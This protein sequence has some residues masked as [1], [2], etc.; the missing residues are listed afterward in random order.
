MNWCW[1]SFV[2]RQH[3][4]IV[5]LSGFV[6]SIL[7]TFLQAL[8]AAGRF[9]QALVEFHRALR[10]RTV[11][12][13]YFHWQLWG[14]YWNITLLY[15]RKD[16]SSIF[17][18]LKFRLRSSSHYEEWIN[19]WKF[20]CV[21]YDCHLVF[22]VFYTLKDSWPKLMKVWQTVKL[23]GARRRSRHSCRWQLLVFTILP[24]H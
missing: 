15:F 10:S 3:I 8:Y 21:L 16:N 17:L 12:L 14:K 6:R 19:R 18:I 2:I 1:K 5:L 9:E 11:M 23:S 4:F 20:L 7:I 13:I 22:F 24:S